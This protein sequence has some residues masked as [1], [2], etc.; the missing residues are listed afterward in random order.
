MPG[1]PLSLPEREEIGL[2]LIE[3]R[4]ITW[5]VIARRV[6]RHATTISREVTANGGRRHYRPALA[7]QRSQR[8]LR[9]P[10]QPVLALAGPIRDRVT[11][12]LEIGRSPDAIWAD[13]HADEVVGRVCV[14]TIYTGVRDVKQREYLR[15]RRPRRRPRQARPASQRTALPSIGA[16]P[17]SVGDRSEPGH[18]EADH[19][20]GRANHSALMC[21]TV[22][23]SRYSI[24]ITMPNGY[25]ATDA[26][27]GLVEGLEQ[28]PAHLRRP[29]TFDQGPGWA[30]W[31]DPDRH[32][33]ARCVVS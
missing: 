26:L 19:I 29:I 5:A 1:A 33:P 28:I 32:P 6:G 24:L 13:L 31:P 18:W 27:A 7:E 21:L 20:I 4:L 11:T 25:T 23:L 16:R 8:C 10:R 9:R 15:M 3:D 14:E 12:E 30:Q 22:R 2:A 17:A